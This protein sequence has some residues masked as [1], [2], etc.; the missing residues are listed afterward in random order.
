MALFARGK[1][2]TVLAS[3]SFA[4]SPA[5]VCADSPSSFRAALNLSSLLPVITTLAP[6]EIIAFAIEK[7][8]PRDPPVTIAHFPCSEIAFIA[9]PNPLVKKIVNSLDNIALLT[10]DSSTRK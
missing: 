3:S 10:H 1:S 6:A 5:K 2:N 4:T 8:I 9:T 7:P